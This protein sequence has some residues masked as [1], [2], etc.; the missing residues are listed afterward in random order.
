MDTKDLFYFLSSFNFLFL[1][2]PFSFRPKLSRDFG[3]YAIGRCH[4]GN[5]KSAILETFSG[6]GRE[7]KYMHY[8]GWHFQISFF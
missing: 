8:G 6:F 5:H 7:E 2:S 3:P 1:Y 4:V